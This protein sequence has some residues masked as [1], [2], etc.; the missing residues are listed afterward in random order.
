MVVPE[1][2]PGVSERAAAVLTSLPAIA[3]VVSFAVFAGGGGLV[4]MQPLW[5]M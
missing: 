4:L 3:E 2:S 5:P 1:L